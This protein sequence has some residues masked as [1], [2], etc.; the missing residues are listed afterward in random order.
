MI[1]NK[2]INQGDKRDILVKKN[3]LSSFL[4]KGTNIFVSFLYIPITLNYLNTTRYGIWMTLTSIVAWIGIF[5]VGLG[6][7]LRNKLTETLAINDKLNAQKYVST[8]YAMISLIVLIVLSIFFIFKHWIDWT[9]ILNTT[10]DYGEELKSLTFLV[11]TL[12]GI[13][14]ILN[15]ISTIFTSDQLPA[16]GGV[17]ELVCNIIS[18]TLIWTITHTKYN[19]LIAFG[20]VTML[21]PVIVY[22]IASIFFFNSKYDYL[23]PSL[24][25]IKLTHA[26]SLTGL[27]IQFFF[28]QIAVIVIFQTSNILIAQFF[29]PAEVT[30]YNIVFKYFSALTMFW[31][32]LMTPLWSAFTHALVHNEIIWMKKTI[33]KLNKLMIF[34]VIIVIIMGLIANYVILKWTNG[35]IDIKPLMIW[36]FALYTLISIWNNIY[37]FFLNGINK[38]KIQIFTSIVAA[39]IH[40]PLAYVLVKYLGMGSEGVVLSMAISLSLFAIAGPLQTYKI[41]REW[42][43]KN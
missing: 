4:I 9:L 33:S 26:K 20:W 6:N 16:I 35:Q 37:S 8:A 14:F 3:I 25:L 30:T 11:V 12:F 34:T 42:K 24:K 18:L 23:K 36:I 27:G 43:I 28:I 15:I 17:I 32:I 31:S 21:T 10:K 2:I 41:L 19:S 7:G 39:I 1:F 5:D 22:M 29:T 38:T 13:K 40:V